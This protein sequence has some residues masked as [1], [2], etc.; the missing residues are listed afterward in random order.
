MDLMAGEQEEP[1]SV[2]LRPSEI[3][4]DER[5]KDGVSG[6]SDA[7]SEPEAALR[8]R[9]LFCVWLATALPNISKLFQ[10]FS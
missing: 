4:E 6:M 3:F 5:D 7:D 2:L 1:S 8:V 9:F 10:T